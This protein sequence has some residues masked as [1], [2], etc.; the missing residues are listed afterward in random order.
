MAK[1]LGVVLGTRGLK[2]DL[3][4][5]LCA[6]RRG[7]GQ[8]QRLALWKAFLSALESGASATD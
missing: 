5:P 4:R 8:S 3:G 1:E 6:Q 7:A 2:G